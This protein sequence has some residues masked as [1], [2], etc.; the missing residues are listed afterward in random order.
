[1]NDE[2]TFS[3]LCF[4]LLTVGLIAYG[5]RIMRFSLSSFA[6]AFAVGV[7][8]YSLWRVRLRASLS[9]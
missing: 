2:N 8:A 4:E 5:L 6:F 1:M 9:F 3:C 7:L